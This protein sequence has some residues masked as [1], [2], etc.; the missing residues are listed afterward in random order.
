[1]PLILDSPLNDKML[2]GMKGTTSKW[3][4]NIYNPT[5][6]RKIKQQV[7]MLTKIF[8][9]FVFIDGCSDISHGIDGFQEGIFITMVI[10]C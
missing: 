9:S 2:G 1:M 3:N 4:S 10:F 5:T 8:P 6:S 7:F